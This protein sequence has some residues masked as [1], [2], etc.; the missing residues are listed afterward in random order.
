MT[1]SRLD[2]SDNTIALTSG[3]ARLWA[4]L[5]GVNAYQDDRDSFPKNGLLPITILE[6]SCPCGKPSSQV[7]PK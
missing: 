6:L 2:I 1:A 7:S 3:K 4:I 5:V